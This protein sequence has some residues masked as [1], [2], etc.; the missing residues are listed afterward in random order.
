MT[1][2]K[3]RGTPAA[4]QQRSN[5]MT[6]QQIEQGLVGG[7]QLVK[8]GFALAL[9]AVVAL[10]TM[11]LASTAPAPRAAFLAVAQPVIGRS[12][13]VTGLVFDGARYTHAPIAVGAPA[14]PVIGRSA[15]VTGLVFDGAAYR[16]A[17]IRVA[18][19]SVGAGYTVTAPIFDGAVYRSAPVRVSG[20]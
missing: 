12:A 2:S 13:V 15:V 18:G 16:S 11:R 5:T 20:H 6:I 19:S 8:I 3:S 7:R 4:K 17:A 9:A 1:S 14:Q 10:L